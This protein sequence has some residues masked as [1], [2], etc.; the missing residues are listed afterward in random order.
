ML[1]APHVVVTGGLDPLG[2]A[3][4]LRDAITAKQHGMACAVIGT[5]WTRQDRSAVRGI[6]PRHPDAVEAALREALPRAC[7]VKIGM[8]PNAPIATAIRLAL[9]DF[10]GAI[11]YDPVL[12]ASSGHPLYVGE[13]TAIAD[14]AHATTLVTPNLS[15]AAFFLGKTIDSAEDA[16]LAARALF[17]QLG[18]A[19]L[20][21]GGHLR[22]EAVD[23][24]C[25]RDGEETFV[26]PRV[27]GESPR[28]TGCAL[29]TAIAI[30]LGWGKTL[31]DAIGG[32]KAWLADRIA[33]A[34]QVGD[35]WHLG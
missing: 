31:R 14:L 5:A 24:L 11:V 2:G 9:S 3:G 27:P 8:V 28:G 34:H 1:D 33:A 6:E 19:V 4:I 17:E 30:G 29:A 18:V 20:V 7:A 23:S 35:D 21:K 10:A 32:A 13:K 16:R 15:E 22:G 26:L 25:F 12:M